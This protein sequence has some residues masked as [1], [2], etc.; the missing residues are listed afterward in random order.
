MLFCRI[1]VL[2]FLYLITRIDNFFSKNKMSKSPFS[3]ESQ[4]MSH[5]YHAHE[6]QGSVKAPLFQTSTFAFKTAG[7]GKAYFELAYGLREP[8]PGEK[9][10]MIYSRV[11]NPTLEN[12]EKRLAL[13]DRGEEAALFASGMAAISTTMFT[14]L[15]PGDLLLFGSPVYGGTDHF[16]HHILPR[17]GIKTLMFTAR[18]SRAD[19]LGRIENQFPGEKPALIYVETPGNPT[20]SIID[21]EMCASLSRQFSTPER[22]TVLA[23]D[24][25]FLGPV[26]QHP[27]KFGAH[28]VIYSATKFIGGHS[29]MVAGA[30]VGSHRLISTIKGT[31]TFMG[32]M[33]DPHSAWL[34]MRSL[35]TLNVRMEQQVKGATRVAAFLKSHPKVKTIHYLGF[36]QDDDSQ[37]RI[38]E[39][40]CL[41]AGSMVAFEVVG[42]EEEAFRFLDNLSLFKLAVSLGSTES[43]AEHPATMTHVDVSPE[44]R[45]KLGITPALVRLSIGLEDPDDLIEVVRRALD[46][47]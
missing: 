1:V 34:I 11:N 4:M 25:T 42:G 46:A 44:D 45:Q 37:K 19:I 28:L 14:F 38:F 31:R 26:F 32:S 17:F 41:S 2:I 22:E 21:I 12:A 23:V 30:C 5:G 7:E 47:V 9:A 39:K 43:L 33:L 20:N 35:E 36:L 13:W 40:Q 15:R 18:D 10:G 24:N 16:I 3:P 27:L 6:H 8:K 29:D